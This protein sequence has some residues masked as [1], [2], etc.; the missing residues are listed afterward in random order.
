VQF[1]RQGRSGTSGGTGIV[2]RTFHR[3]DNY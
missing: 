1:V 3:V 2:L